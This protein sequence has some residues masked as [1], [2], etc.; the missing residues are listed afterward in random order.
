MKDY[1]RARQITLMKNYRSSQTILDTAYRLIKH[2][3]PD[4]LESRLGISKKLISQNKKTANTP[5]Q[6]F[7]SNSADEEAD[8]VSAEIKKLKKTINI[9]ILRC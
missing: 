2:N 4:T 7:L 9:P 6:L 8:Y 5:V 3:D 1:K